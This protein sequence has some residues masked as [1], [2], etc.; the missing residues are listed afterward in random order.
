MLLMIHIWSF[1]TAVNTLVSNTIGEGK[2]DQVI[3]IILRMNKLSIMINLLVRTNSFIFPEFL[4]RIYSDDGSLISEAIPVLYIVTGALL[5][6]SVA[7]NWFSGI[8]GTANTK[9]ALLSEVSTIVLYLT[10]MFIMT[11]AFNASLPVT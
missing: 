11:F 10:Y 2:P 9:V 3:P 4:I 8:S 5:P 6:L 1:S 7:V